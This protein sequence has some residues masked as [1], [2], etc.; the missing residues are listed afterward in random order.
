MAFRGKTL[1]SA[2]LILVVLPSYILSVYN[3]SEVYL[4]DNVMNRGWYSFPAKM[5]HAVLSQPYDGGDVTPL[6][7]GLRGD[8]VLCCGLSGHS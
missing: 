1:E 4:L 2:M 5:A 8:D 6:V 7:C 3:Q